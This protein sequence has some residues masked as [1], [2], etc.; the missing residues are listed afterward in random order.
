MRASARPV[1]RRN[2]RTPCYQVSGSGHALLTGSTGRR[3]DDQSSTLDL[4][5]RLFGVRHWTEIC[6]HD[7]DITLKTDN[8]F[9]IYIATN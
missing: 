9:L 6:G 1:P 5:E 3:Q 4:P 8:I 7:A 2:S